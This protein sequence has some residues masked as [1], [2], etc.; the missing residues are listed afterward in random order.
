[1]VYLA[2]LVILLLALGSEADQQF[3]IKCYSRPDQQGRAITIQT[4]Y[5]DWNLLCCTHE[6]GASFEVISF[7][8]LSCNC[9]AKPTVDY[10]NESSAYHFNDS[11]E[12]TEFNPN[13]DDAGL[14]ITATESFTGTG[15]FLLGNVL[16]F[17]EVDHHTVFCYSEPNLEGYYVVFCTMNFDDRMICCDVRAQS[18]YVITDYIDGNRQIYEGYSC[19]TTQ[20]I[21]RSCCYHSHR[22]CNGDSN[23]VSL[24]PGITA[25][26]DCC[27][28]GFGASFKLAI[29]KDISVLT[30][31][32]F[33][34]VR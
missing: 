18:L 12:P 32:T 24:R 10:R 29:S 31:L 17:P 34:K 19:P 5:T 4:H 30:V 2:L 3:T 11:E 1:M 22:D 7:V 14:A 25:F 23:H 20:N 27:R 28:N 16:T 26:R 6:L 8:N 9:P 21:T 15:E 13:K 33:D